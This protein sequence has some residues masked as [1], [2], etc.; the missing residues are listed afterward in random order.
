MTAGY[1]EHPD[2]APGAG[3]SRSPPPT[4]RESLKRILKT[5]ESP[6]LDRGR[7]VS[8]APSPRSGAGTD[9]P[10]LR[11]RCAPLRAAPRPWLRGAEPALPAAA[12]ATVPPCSAKT[13]P[14][15]A[16]PAPSRQRFPWKQR[17]GGR[18]SEPLPAGAKRQ[19][20][21]CGQGGEPRRH[22]SPAASRQQV[23][24]PARRLTAERGRS[25][26]LTGDDEQQ[27]CV[28]HQ[29]TEGAE[30]P[31][32]FHLIYVGCGRGPGSGRSRARL[33]P[34]HT[35]GPGQGSF[36]KSQSHPT[37]L[38]LRG[39]KYKIHSRRLKLARRWEATFL[40]MKQ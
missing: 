11:A 25:L 4:E 14:R 32:I 13:P 30:E 37:N 9:C 31:P 3:P 35:A 34:S 5:Q 7:S 16:L 10:G 8:H 24:C 2:C 23:V 1:A 18:G 38:G 19:E 27:R 6:R 17:R 29:V 33:N 28:E 26:L 20:L 12:A 36:P 21:S 15:A 22:R 40:G 39:S